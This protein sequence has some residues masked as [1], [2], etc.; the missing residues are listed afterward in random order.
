MKC[1]VSGIFAP[2]TE[3]TWSD[4]VTL[5]GGRSG[6]CGGCWCTWWRMTRGDWQSASK[7][8]R[9]EHIRGLVAA[10]E[11]IGIVY[12]TDSTP[13]GWCA[14]A[15]RVSYP[16]LLRSPIA[17]PKDNLSSWII[18]CLFVRAGHRRRGLTR[19]LIISAAAYAFDQGAEVVDAFPQVMSPERKGYVDLFVGTEQSF[20]RAGFSRLEARGVNRVMVRKVRDTNGTCKPNLETINSA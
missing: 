9:R 10:G 5:F 16:T 11:P 4:F 3:A 15:P 17:F 12:F 7:D 2:L 8:E 1:A 6:G 20:L 13:V 18:S 19:E 14:V